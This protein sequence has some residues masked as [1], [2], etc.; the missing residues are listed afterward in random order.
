MVINFRTGVMKINKAY[1]FR[2]EPNAEQ[3][4]ILNNLVGSARFVWNQ[5]LAI[6]FE[7]FA[8]NEFINATNLVNKIMDIKAN[9]DFDFLKTHANAVS[10]QQKVRD[11]ASAWSRFF[12]P[13]VHARLKENK[14]KPKKPKFF[15]LPDGT[16]IQLRPLMPR[17]KR[18]SDGCDSIRLVQFDKYCKVD[19]NR[20]KLPNGVGF[21]KFRKSQ[22]ILGTIKNV[23]ISKKSGRWYVSFGT[24]REVEKPIHPSATAI[25][26]DLGITKFITTSN[27]DV[28]Q[29]KNSFKANQ[30]K[31]AKLQRQ[32]SRKV[33]FSQNW[34]KQNRKIQKLHHHIANV[35]H[36]YLHKITTTISKNHAMIVCEDLK[37]ANM[38]KSASGSLENKGRN[39]KA[40]SGLNKSI[41]DQGWSM[42]LT[43]LEYKQQWQGGLLVKVNPRF[44]SQTC[45]ECKHVAKENRQTQA[46]FECVECGYIANADVNAARNIL[47]A[48]HAVL[49]V[50]GGRSKGR[51]M[52]QKTSD[53]VRMSPKS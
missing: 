19:G 36:D 4:V 12:D 51:P 23:T 29:P 16:E 7:M 22:D 40:K 20:V 28:I 49:S 34:K 48:G 14:K 13:K 3:E 44:T 33:L 18:K 52:K 26:I 32:L 15:K 41:L 46:K 25:G 24:E 27:A 30:A 21:V 50:E 43:M 1:K 53:T 5:M 38:S 35:R 31:L 2:L 39:V 10:L 42:A 47:A 45:F 9:P 17:F 8:K 37:V 11:L 6:S